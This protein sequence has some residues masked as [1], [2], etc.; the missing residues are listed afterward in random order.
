MSYEGYSQFLCKK[1]HQ[2]TVDAH[3]LMHGGEDEVRCP[4]CGGRP[5]WE[6]MVNLTNG[7]FDEDDN[8]IDNYVELKIKSET[9]GF[10]SSCGKKHICDVTY[11]IPE[12]KGRWVQDEEAE[13]N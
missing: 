1:G 8:R 2:W 11:Q 7:S 3:L 12:D 6:N 13:G 9:S 4:K 5:A 10:C